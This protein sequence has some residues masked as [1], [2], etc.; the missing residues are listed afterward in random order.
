[1]APPVVLPDLQTLTVDA[2]AALA[3]L[4]AGN[5]RFVANHPLD[6][7]HDSLYRQQLTQAQHPF[8]MILGCVDSRVIPELLFDCGFGDLLVI[9]TAGHAIDEVTVGSIEFGADVLEIPL[10]VVLGHEHCGAVKATINMLD[11][12]QTAPDRIAVLVDH[13][14]PAVAEID[15]HDPNRLDAAIRANVLHTVVELQQI[16]L[17]AQREDAGL[18]RIVGAYYSLVSGVVELLTTPHDYVKRN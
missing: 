9:R 18:L 3:F 15:I 8:A 17:L 6:P 5:A 1:M 2:A 16:P 13:L 11:Q 4:L 10:L 14:R 12:Q 7:H